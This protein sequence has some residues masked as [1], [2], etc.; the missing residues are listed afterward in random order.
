MNA[1]LYTRSDSEYEHLRGGIE[2]EYP[3]IDIVRAPMEGHKYYHIGYD[4]VIVALEGAEG[5]E[6]VS[7]YSGRF[8]TSRVIWITSDEHFAA[9]AMRLH[10][11][12]F[13]K[14]PFDQ[15]V[16]DKAIREALKDNPGRNQW[17]FG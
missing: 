7:E 3:N 2:S 11:Y 15:S 14:R 5:M 8:K 9:T 1:I 12:D 17:N 16:V 6:V 10:I 4:L 13:I